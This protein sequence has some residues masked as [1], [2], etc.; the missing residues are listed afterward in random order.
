LIPLI[1]WCEKVGFDIIQTLPLNDTAGHNSPF[2]PTSSFSLNPLLL[3]L[4]QLPNY[5]NQSEDMKFIINE[6]QKINGEPTIN[7]FQV[8]ELKKN[9]FGNIMKCN[10]IF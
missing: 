3:S 1:D 2:S 5:E 4:T 8:R 7:W 9:G 10:K 6:L